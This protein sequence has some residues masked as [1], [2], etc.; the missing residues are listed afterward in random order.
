MRINIQQLFSEW[1]TKETE[2]TVVL[3]FKS[4]R[5]NYN[6]KPF[7]FP[8]EIF[9]D[10]LF[11]E[12]LGMYVGD[13]DMHRKEKNHLTYASKDVDIAK[14]IL[15]FLRNRLNIQ[16]RD[17]TITI[18]HGFIPPNIPTLSKRL[19]FS[20]FKR[21]FSTR[22]RYPAIQI[23]INGHIFRLVFE[24]IMKIFLMSDFLNNPPLRRGFLRGLFA[25]EG[26]VAIDYQE[27]YI[28]YI[29]F[30][31]SIKEKDIATLIQNGLEKEGI[32]SRLVTRERNNSIEVN[33]QN[34]SNYLKCWQINMF[35]GCQRKKEK[36]LSIAK[37]SKV[38]GIIPQREL[39]LLSER[40]T[41]K[42]LAE[43]VGSW[44][45]NVCR[46]LKG[47]IWFS[48]DQIR[49]LEQMGINLT[50]TRLRIGNLTELPYS[51]E[52]IQLFIPAIS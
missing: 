36:F 19:K 29:G 45:G 11:A 38:Y 7:E 8:K 44:Q 41:Q 2:K 30:T 13:G 24:K 18:S 34:W 12:A 27:Q 17:L 20:N 42:E 47:N 39:D 50:I 33:I 40:F 25:A 3:W 14:F 28:A 9:I 22:N 5:G 16:N 51:E 6:R 49:T 48:L 26:C 52:T 21:H 46:M 15:D 32:D 4:K 43:I 35:D 31:L 37:N 23:Q 1:V 10:E